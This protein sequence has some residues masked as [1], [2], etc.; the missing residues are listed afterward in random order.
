MED[1]KSNLSGNSTLYKCIDLETKEQ[2]YIR[3]FVTLSD[4]TSL[5]SKYMIFKHRYLLPIIEQF[6][7]NDNYF[8][9]TYFFP[10]L[11][12]YLSKNANRT[13]FTP[14][15]IIKIGKQ[16]CETTQYL[17]KRQHVHNHMNL[18]QILLASD[19][20]DILLA[21]VENISDAYETC[22][23]SSN[24]NTLK[25]RINAMIKQ[26]DTQSILEQMKEDMENIV[27]TNQFTKDIKSIGNCL[28]QLMVLDA[29]FNI[30]KELTTFNQQQFTSN[31]QQ[32]IQTLVTRQLKRLN[33][34]EEYS[35]EIYQVLAHLIDGELKS[36]HEILKQVS[37]TQRIDYALTNLA[38]SKKRK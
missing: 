34:L 28:V 20:M 17:H 33:I 30:Q 27:E 23:A 38:Q 26:H 1:S 8:Y 25:K 14:L 13:P 5:S 19:Q 3:K 12:N 21:G 37:Q 6:S 18:E 36:A 15:Q 22:S 16:L 35:M 11:A 4:Y 7:S 31:T 32:S 2:V 29:S 24:E 9:K 10:S